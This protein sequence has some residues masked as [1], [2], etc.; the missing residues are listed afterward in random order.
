M[1]RITVVHLHAAFNPAVSVTEELHRSMHRAIAMGLEK[2][3]VGLLIVELGL[4]A[5]S[6]GVIV[7]AF[8]AI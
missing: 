2:H 7:S 8:I 5:A 6:N 1:F 3:L 4:T